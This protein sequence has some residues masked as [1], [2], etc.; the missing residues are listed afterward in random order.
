MEVINQRTKEIHVVIG[1][2]V[3][4]P[5]REAAQELLDKYNF[6]YLILGDE[7]IAEIPCIE[8]THEPDWKK[9][10]DY[11]AIKYN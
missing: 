1:P 2:R 6:H 9:M 4:A 10:V 5:T 11:E 3:I 7:L 8:G